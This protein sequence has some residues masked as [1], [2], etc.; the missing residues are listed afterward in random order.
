MA[1]AEVVEAVDGLP[2]RSGAERAIRVS[3]PAAV[4]VGPARSIEA[5]STEVVAPSR[6]S[7]RRATSTVAASQRAGVVRRALAASPVARPVAKVARVAEL[8]V[9][10]ARVA[11]S[12]PSLDTQSPRRDAAAPPQRTSDRVVDAPPRRVATRRAEASDQLRSERATGTVAAAQRGFVRAAERPFAPAPSS[13]GRP[14]AVWADAP[15]VAASSGGAPSIAASG[16]APVAARIARRGEAPVRIAEAPVRAERS[17]VGTDR[18]EAV[19]V[20][21]S[22]GAV[23]PVLV[24]AQAAEPVVADAAAPER[25]RRSR[26]VAKAPATSAAMQRQGAPVATLS[27]PVV[28]RPARSWAPSSATP[29]RS[30]AR[31]RW[32]AAS[33]V[34]AAQRGG[35]VVTLSASPA[36]RPSATLADRVSD[37]RAVDGVSSA[38]RTVQPVIA[39]SGGVE[40]RDVTERPGA[41]RAGVVARPDF[42]ER[43]GDVGRSGGERVV[44]AVA[45]DRGAV[46]SVLTGREASVVAGTVTAAQRGEG[47]VRT[48]S[49]S[50]VVRPSRVVASDRL[51]ARAEAPSDEGRSGEAAVGG[52]RSAS[53]FAAPSARSV[54]SADAKGSARLDRSATR[55]SR[56]VPGGGT[57][58]WAPSAPVA[59]A[60]PVA[61]GG[62]ARRGRAYATVAAAQRGVRRAAA[63]SESPVVRANPEVAISDRMPTLARATA[64]GLAPQVEAAAPAAGMVRSLARLEAGV[65]VDGTGRAMTAA[66]PVVGAARSE[67][68]A[69]GGGAAFVAL[70]RL[71]AAEARPAG[72]VVVGKASASELPRFIADRQAVA[73]SVTRHLAVSSDHR[74][75]SVAPAAGVAEGA[76]LAPSAARASRSSGRRVMAP[77]YG[78]PSSERVAAT[79]APPSVRAAAGRAPELQVGPARRVLGLDNGRAATASL[80][81]PSGLGFT[82]IVVAEAASPAVSADGRATA[83]GDAAAPQERSAAGRSASRGVGARAIA[84]AAPGVL[85]TPTVVAEAQPVSGSSRRQAWARPGMSWAEARAMAPAGADQGAYARAVVAGLDRLTG[86]AERTTFVGQP[87]VPAVPGTPSAVE[88]RAGVSAV[89]ARTDAAGR[90]EV[91]APRGAGGPAMVAP[92]AAGADVAAA[93]ERPAGLASRVVG[94]RSARASEVGAEG[95][96]VDPSLGPAP[97]GDRWWWTVSQLGNTSS[98]VG[99]GRA[100]AP[101]AVADGRSPGWARRVLAQDDPAG[102]GGGSEARLA[103]VVQRRSDIL[104]SLASARTAEDVVRVILDRGDS[105]RSLA[106]VLPSP[107]RRLVE[108]IAATGGEALGEEAPRANVGAFRN[109]APEG[110]VLRPSGGASGSGRRLSPLSTAT[111]G[112]GVGASNVMRLAGKLMNLIH[113]A[114]VERRKSEAQR[115]VRMAS[116]ETGTEGSGGAPA[117][118]G[119]GQNANIEALRR[120]VLEAVLRQLETGRLRTEEDPDG[121]GIWW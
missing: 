7:A 12:A 86:R 61:D 58:L 10:P 113:L 78:Q 85:V 70:A 18:G 6:L 109:K 52:A 103:Q 105:V 104:G 23:A 17:V 72:A 98:G 34:A 97:T 59:E 42:I 89:G 76:P 5:A 99:R 13:V 90:G 120:D 57:V 96:R 22:L 117:A 119:S 67:D 29:E 25:A 11:I 66:A 80:P 100:V 20:A 30:A 79:R 101:G 54:G 95:L 88:Q 50:P 64:S 84:A 39:R 107:A 43:V 44:R 3:A 15:R 65:R 51:S 62:V 82:S 40:R 32:A 31:G 19:R 36:Q 56:V 118:G 75:L 60:T 45:G 71:V 93:Q 47:V 55:A 46:G 111:R 106:Q 24:R 9:R 26:S 121:H 37:R 114:E 1:R 28:T 73:P 87:V 48:L 115:Q 53:A 92:R 112:R 74:L 14:S 33:T 4:V 16:E 27:A 35:A 81:Y 63:V 108:T 116:E 102:A 77:T 21:R 38:G 69:A 110:E 68:V 2:A 41:A 8:A 94:R 91:R 83:R 49:A